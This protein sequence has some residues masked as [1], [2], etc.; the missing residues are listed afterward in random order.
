MKLALISFTG[1]GSRLCRSLSEAL[2]MQGY[3][4]EAYAMKK[5]AES[6]RLIPLTKPLQEWTGEMFAKCDAICF[7]GASGIAVR[8]I[9]P[10][11]R[12]KTKDP[13]VVVMDEKGIFAISLLSGHL[14]GANDLAGVLANLT[15]AIPVITTATDVN[16]R[17]AVDVFAKKNR[18]YIDNMTYAKEISADVLDE[19]PVGF[20]SDFPVLDQIPEEIIP[21]TKE[22]VFKGTAG[23]AVT[24]HEEIM[25]FKHTLHL[26]PRVLTVGIG[27]RR[28][29]DAADIEKA[30]LESCS[31]AGISVHG[32]EQITSIDLKSEEPGII[33]FCEKYKIPFITY[34]K[35]ELSEVR[36]TF[37]ESEFVKEITGVSNVCERSAVLGS[38]SGRLIQKKRAAKDSE[39][40]LGI[41]TAIALREWSVEF[42]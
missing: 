26:I 3:C 6:N 41:T 28:G 38:L 11:V 1:R 18:L 42:E 15:G 27:C 32:I 24:L 31:A 30:V 40:A 10:F 36:G 35:E 9:A 16:G 34:S 29:T 5:Y 13:A 21:V 12:D 20:Y 4:C 33:S 8:S 14:G 23:I 39:K 19:K 37:T 2:E 25:P 17:F 22:Q 7:I